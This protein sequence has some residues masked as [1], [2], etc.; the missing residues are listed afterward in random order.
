MHYYPPMNK[1]EQMK[2]A[3]L[4]EYVEAMFDDCGAM[5]VEDIKIGMAQ[6]A[7][8]KVTVAQVVAVCEVLVAEKMIEK[9]G[10]G[11]KTTDA[12]EEEKEWKFAEAFCQ[13]VAEHTIKK[14]AK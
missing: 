7:G 3:E 2:K 9:N 5:T 1:E 8:A 10:D 6:G 12:F 4:L 14:A 11:Y 13:A